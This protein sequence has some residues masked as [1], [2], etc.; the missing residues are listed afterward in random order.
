VRADVHRYA[1]SPETHTRQA[2]LD[3]EL[4]SVAAGGDITGQHINTRTRNFR[5][6]AVLAGAGQSS[7]YSFAL[8]SGY[9]NRPASEPDGRRFPRAPGM[10]PSRSR[11]RRGRGQGRSPARL[12]WQA[13][14][15]A[16]AH[17]QAL[18]P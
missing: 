15:M 17:G 10:T 16:S 13:A 12:S 11:G 9:E 8:R 4:T 1:I 5:S 7:S 18:G 3:T 14:A 2:R 6:S